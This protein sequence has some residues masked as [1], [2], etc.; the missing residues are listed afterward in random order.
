M[1]QQLSINLRYCHSSSLDE[2]HKICRRTAIRLPTWLTAVSSRCLTTF[3]AK[4][5]AF[6]SYM[7]QNA[8]F[9]LPWLDN[10]LASFATC[11]CNQRSGFSELQA[12]NCILPTQWTWLLCC[13]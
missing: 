6:N 3:P 4:I 1:R 10:S 13:V 5:P 9:C 2:P 8:Y 12:P 7:R 11:L